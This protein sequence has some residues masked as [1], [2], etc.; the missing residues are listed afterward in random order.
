MVNK[1][2]YKVFFDAHLG[3]VLLE[4]RFLFGLPE[5]GIYPTDMVE[6]NRGELDILWHAS[7]RVLRS[8]ECISLSLERHP[9]TYKCLICTRFDYRWKSNQMLQSNTKR[10]N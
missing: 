6:M 7:K 2:T 3:S 10:I 8:S 1:A 9:R 4:R 5:K